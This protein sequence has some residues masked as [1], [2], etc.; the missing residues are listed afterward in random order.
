MTREGSSNVPNVSNHCS[1]FKN[2]TLVFTCIGTPELPKS[3]LV[4]YYLEFQI[5]FDDSKKIPKI[6]IE[7]LI[8]CYD[9]HPGIFLVALLNKKNV[10]F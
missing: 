6:F 3:R 8:L 5:F 7:P 1:T 9:M 2:H 10:L 4:Y